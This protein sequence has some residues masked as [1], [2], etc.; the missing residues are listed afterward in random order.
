MIRV[1]TRHLSLLV[2]LW[3]LIGS[4]CEESHPPKVVERPGSARVVFVL[5]RTTPEGAVA[6]VTATAHGDQGAQSVELQGSGTLWQ[7]WFTSLPGGPLAGFQAEAFDSSGTRRFQAEVTREPLESSRPGLI[8]LAGDDSSAAVPSS[9]NSPPSI[10]AVVG[11]RASVAPGET[12]RLRAVARDPDADDALSYTWQPGEGT[13]DDASAVAPTWT[14][15]ASGGQQTVMLVVRDSR[16]GVTSLLFTLEVSEAASFNQQGPVVLNRWPAAAG[17]VSLSPRIVGVG[18]EVTLELQGAGDA[19]SDPLTYQ[20]TATC[21]GSRVDG[22]G[23]MFRFLPT[24]PRDTTTCDNCQ[25]SVQIEDAYGGSASY[26]LGL[27]VK[28]LQPPTIRSTSATALSATPGELL[29]L[30]ISAEDPFGGALTY[31]WT[32]NTGVLGVPVQTGDT[33]EVPWTALSC[34]PTGVT[35]TIEVTVTNSVGL[36]V[37]IRYQ[38]NWNGPAC[39][40][41]PCSVQLDQRSQPELTLQTDCTTDTPVFIPDGLM[42]DGSGH[43]LVAVDP[44]SSSFRGA[45]LRNQGAT[46]HVRNLR[47]RAQG[48]LKDGPCDAGDDRLRGILWLGASGSIVDSEVLDIHRN[49]PAAS[50]PEGEPRGCQEG[51]AIEVRNRDASVQQQVEIR[52]NRVN[53]YQKV[54]ILVAGRVNATIA[55]NT[56]TGAGP[57]AYIAQNGVQ[58]SD[59]ATGQVTENQISNHAYAYTGGTDVASGLIVAGGPY[60]GIALVQDALV[61]GNTLTGNDV[62]IYLDQAEADGSEL[63]TP[64]RIQVL[65]NTLRNDGVTNALPYQAG[66]SDLG[67]GNIIHSNTIIGAG[68]DPTTQPGATFDV[69]VVAGPASQVAFLTPPGAVAVGACSGRVVVQGQDSKGNLSKPTPATFNLTASGAAAQGLAFYTDAACAGTSVNSVALSTP[70]AAATF[71]FKATQPGAVTLSAS[72][73]SLSGSQAQNISGP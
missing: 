4:G 42:L 48:L 26:S 12:I 8:I 51:H 19:D 20:W 65:D 10:S 13:F 25:V 5:P 16:G 18:Q 61:Q 7:G 60:Y 43:E 6:R 67:G 58:L 46:A 49:Q 73:G 23:A 41:P 34:V 15:P 44:A 64:T 29:K 57:V 17:L 37:R 55:Q 39:S 72:N 68:Y 54:G 14:A 35:P 56:V 52:G 3:M 31:R 1:D 47:L 32:A 66:I 22:S 40:H 9:G 11:S 2:G 59:G 53:G 36:S 21:E 28:S 62:G 38:V 24:L 33:S 71:Y 30:S 70:E 69:D 63:A 50:S 45:I 27:C